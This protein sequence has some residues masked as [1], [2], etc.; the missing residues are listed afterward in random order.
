MIVLEEIVGD[1]PGDKEDMLEAQNKLS[2]A[3]KIPGWWKGCAPLMN[4]G[5]ISILKKNFREKR[6]MIIRRLAG[7][8]VPVWLYSE[9]NG[10]NFLRPFYL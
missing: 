4:S 9:R 2:A 8:H 3:R 5:S 7:Y 10:K 6:K 1:M